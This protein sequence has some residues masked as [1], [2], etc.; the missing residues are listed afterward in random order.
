MAPCAGK[1]V[2]SLI[3]MLSYLSLFRLRYET[4]DM[5][6]SIKEKVFIFCIDM[7]LHHQSFLRNHIGALSGSFASGLIPVLCYSFS[8]VVGYRE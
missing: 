8:P 2:M 5:M 7:V 6:R 3:N 4:F 1:K